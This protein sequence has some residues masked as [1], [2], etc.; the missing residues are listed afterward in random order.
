MSWQN[1]LQNVLANNV[2]ESTG[3]TASN[4]S[5]IAAI[6][7]ISDGT[8]KA[9]SPSTFS[10]LSYAMDHDGT[11]VTINELNNLVDAFNHQGE[12]SKPG[13]IRLNRVSYTTLSFNPDRQVLQL[14]KNV[15]GAVIAKTKTTFVI[16]TYN[17]SLKFTN[18]SG[19]DEPQNLTMVKYA[20]EQLQTI[21][22]D[23]SM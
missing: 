10:L 20:V 9:A 12:C 7:Q 13:G 14:K 18:Y 8:I 2:D 5:E 4:L 23:E 3:L 16:G 11:K 6:V 1:H 17:T 19:S 15:G 21:L 22:L